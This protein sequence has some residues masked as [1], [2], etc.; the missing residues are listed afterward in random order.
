[1]IIFSK[2]LRKRSGDVDTILVTSVLETPLDSKNWSLGKRVFSGS[3]MS[4]GG[5]FLMIFEI[6][7]SVN[8]WFLKNAR[9][10]SYL[11]VVP[12]LRFL[13]AVRAFSGGNPHEFMR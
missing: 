1:M 9:T 5:R 4:N 8:P 6:W 13:D 12:N 11:F 7:V 2:L 3:H 10:E